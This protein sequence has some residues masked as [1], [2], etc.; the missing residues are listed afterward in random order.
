MSGSAVSDAGDNVMPSFGGV[1]K[2]NLVTCHP[3]LQIIFQEVVQHFDCAVIAGHRAEQLQRYLFGM[4]LSQVDWPDSLHNST[5][6]M[7]ADVVPY[8]VDWKDT[9]RFYHFAGLV[10]GI[11]ICFKQQEII[12]Y[13]LRW[14]GDWDGDTELHDQSFMDLPHFE[15][16]KL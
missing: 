13:D 10:R 15:L 7:A 14:G 11:A 5:P 9:D 6:A 1:S 2:A 3:D 16:V 4:E 8:P 12:T